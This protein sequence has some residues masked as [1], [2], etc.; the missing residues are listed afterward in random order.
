[1]TLIHQEAS[2]DFLEKSERRA[3][4]SL[5]GF[6]MM[7]WGV[8]WGCCGGSGGLWGGSVDTGP[9][10]MRW[11]FEGGWGGGG[12]FW[13]G[14]VGAGPLL[15]VSESISMSLGSGLGTQYHP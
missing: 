4:L 6:D 10:G 8:G 15:S 9:S 12:C 3:A 13:G 5:A 11:Y 14:T 7:I 1:M 2:E